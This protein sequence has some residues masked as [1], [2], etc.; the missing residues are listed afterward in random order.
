MPEGHVR[1]APFRFSAIDERE[2]DV[3]GR[4]SAGKKIEPLEDEP[5][6]VTPQARTCF[7]YRGPTSTPWN[8][9]EPPDGVSRQPRMFMVVDFPEPLGPMMATNSP[10]ES[11]NWLLQGRGPRLLPSLDSGDITKL[12]QRFDGRACLFDL[13]WPVHL[14][15]FNA[16]TIRGVPGATWAEW[17]R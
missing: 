4:V 14:A 13:D 3:L 10:G 11:R 6:V 9:Y 15:S 2:F 5:K 8:R 1:G 7:R 16:S 17:I 12:K